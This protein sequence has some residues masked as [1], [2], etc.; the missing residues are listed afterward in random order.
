MI[1]ITGDTHGGIDMEKLNKENFP[2]QHRLT[3]QD[4]LIVAGD[5]GFIWQDNKEQ[6]QWLEL[7][8]ELNYTTLFIDGNHENFEQ[9]NSFPVE[10]WMGGKIH[11]IHDS[12]L[13]LMRG[14]VFTIDDKTIFTFGGGTSIDRMFR[15]AY[16]SWWPEEMPSA[17][18]Y[19][20]GLDNLEAHNWQ[21]DCVISH[22]G[23]TKIIR[24]LDE[25][26]GADALTEYLQE[27]SEK[28]QFE[29]WYFGHYHIDKFLQ[30]K[31]PRKQSFR[32][33]YQDKVKLGE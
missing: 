7:F 3:K 8:K 24:A 9:L 32:A 5:F 25:K 29:K 12:I 27:L 13:H 1:Y 15:R 26:F 16:I 10:T 33:L 4:Y 30:G 11:R 6:R 28:L 2:E 23:P 31:C 20:V 14:Q 21:V 18:E 22:T 19:R 17:A